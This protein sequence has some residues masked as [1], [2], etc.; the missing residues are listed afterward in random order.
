MGGLW[1]F[2]ERGSG[3]GNFLYS[4]RAS[5]DS[6]WKV[7]VKR[8]WWKGVRGGSVWL[9]VFSLA[10]VNSVYTR[11]P[12]AVRGS[13]FRKGVSSLR[14]EGWKDLVPVQID[15]EEVGDVVL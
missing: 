4:A 12:G 10:L 14:G 13:V 7:G 5:A 11:D 15:E 3:R 2:L 8:G 1:A 6:M 9:F